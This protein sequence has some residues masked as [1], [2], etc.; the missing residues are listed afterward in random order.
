[1]NSN[2]AKETWTSAQDTIGGA[3]SRDVNRGLGALI[4]GHYKNTQ[5]GGVMGRGGEQKVD[6]FKRERGQDVDLP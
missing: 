6:G 2:I 1:M 3:T 4:D 5:R